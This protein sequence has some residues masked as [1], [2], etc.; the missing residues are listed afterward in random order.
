[1]AVYQVCGLKPWGHHLANVLLHALNAALIF[2]LLRQ[3]TGT[4]WRSLFVAVLFA[5]HP[6]RVESVAWVSER[7]DVLSAF[8]GL[9]TL[10]FYAR[11]AKPKI[12]N[13]KSEIGN[14]LLALFF[15]ALGLMS[16]PMLVTWPCV[17]LLLDYW[18]L[19]RIRNSEFGIRKFRGLLI[20][21]IPFAVLAVASSVV[22]FMVQKNEGGLAVNEDMPLDA[23]AGNALISYCRYLEKMFWPTDLAVFYPHPGYWPLAK[24]L[25]AGVFLC[26][27]SAFLFVKRR[28]HPYLLVGWL[29]YVGT[30]VPVIGL[31]QA[32]EQAMADRYTYVPSLGVLVLIIW[33]ACELTGRWRHQKIALSVSGSAAIILCLALTRHQLGYWKDS[34]SLF[35]HTLE[36]TENNYM[37]HNNLGDALFY[38]GQTIE[39]M[40]QFKES[41]RL[42]PGFAK[43]HYNL[44]DALF[45]EGQTT[46]AM[47]QFQ[48]AIRLKPDFAEAR[49]NLGDALLRQGKTD[50]AISQ[51]QEAIRLKPDYAEAHNNLGIAFGKKGQIVEAASQFQEAIRLKPDFAGAQSNLAKV[52]ELKSKL[53]ER[54]SGPVKP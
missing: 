43:A 17:M 13:R 42:K 32:G 48:E 11:Y 16:K 46:E 31:V 3:M 2:V 1:M 53:N 54:T 35:R 12:G 33:G 51:F 39:A 23:R 44:G 45:D 8:F 14:Y 5:V 24:V 52:L 10:I 6:L 29:W 18:P 19:N 20:E 26:G 4:T 22:T 27:I 37:A 49:Y 28:R 9:L 50:E 30:L 47:S 21:K 36:V 25:L 38:K 15:F 41:I 40:N 34:E 7:K